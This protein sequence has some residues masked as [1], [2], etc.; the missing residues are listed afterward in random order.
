MSISHGGHAHL[1]LADDTLVLYTYCCYDANKSNYKDFIKTEDGEL[2]I[3]RDAF[4]EPKIHVK[5]KRTAS[6]RKKIFAKRVRRDVSISELIEAGRIKVK[7]ASGTWLVR[8]P[9]VDFI[10][11][12][13]LSKIFTEYQDT[14]EIPTHMGLYY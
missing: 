14:G 7:N 4:I 6:G 11:C 1:F 13:L 8:G 12:R 10:A 9:G 5:I 3:A 2:I